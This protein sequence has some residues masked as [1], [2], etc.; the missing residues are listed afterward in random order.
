MAAFPPQAKVVTELKAGCFVPRPK[1]ARELLDARQDPDPQVR[2]RAEECLA[3]QLSDPM[4]LAS[5]RGGHVW[6]GLPADPALQILHLLL[7]GHE[8]E[9][10]A[11]DPQGELLG[12][13]IQFLSDARRQPARL[14]AGRLTPGRGP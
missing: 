1:L 10:E 9:A 11:R 8:E 5:M 13:A 12:R 14:G 6:T 4:L 3:E 2:E 7:N